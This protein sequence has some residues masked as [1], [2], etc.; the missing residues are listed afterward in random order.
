MAIA[1][2][3]TLPRVSKPEPAA[4][5]TPT[6]WRSPERGAPRVTRM[7][8]PTATARLRRAG[9][10]PARVRPRVGLPAKISLFLALILL[11]LAGMTWTLSERALRT[12]LTEEFTSKGT[13][14]ANSLASTG[15][16]LVLTRDASTVQALVDQFAAIS[17]VA[18]V[19]V[20][21]AQKTMIAHTFVPLVPPG[22]ID[23]NP[24]PGDAAK[25]QV[26]DIQYPDPVSGELREIIDIGVPML[27]GTIGTVR[28]G[29]NKALIVAAATKSGKSLLVVFVGFAVVAT[30]A[31]VIFAQRITRPVALLVRVAE[32]V[33][34]GDLSKAV[35]VTSHDEIGV[36][37]ETFNQTMVRLRGLV[38]TEAE[39]DE[40]RR[41]RE[42]LQLHITQFLDTVTEITKGDLTRRG[43]VTSDVLG[44]VVDATNV[45]VQEIATIIAGVRLAAG[46]VAQSSNEMIASAG[47][48]AAGSQ[49]Q[50]REAMAVASAVEELTRSVKQVAEIGE[51]AAHAARQALEASQ[52]GDQAVRNSLDGMQRIRGEVQAI[53]KKIKSLGDRSL[54][55][56]E[57]VNTIEEIA[58]QTNLLAL[59]AA[60]EAAGAGDAGLR[61]AV[62]ADEVR[63]LAERS[64]KATKD[65][66]AL[67]KNVHAETHDAIVVM[68]QGTNEVESGY[69]VTVQAGE[70]LKD[71]AQISQKS[72]E[73][74]HDISRA[75]Q[76][77]VR[78]A[79]GVATAVKSIAG[80]AVQTEQGALQTRKTVDQLVRLA[81]ELTA[82]LTRFKLST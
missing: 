31:G 17:G 8:T 12:R 14:I 57:I 25:A 75:T 54:E 80:V 44:N 9:E 72:A 41:R 45:M 34:Q 3:E 30:L 82:S 60:I 65:I 63:K 15:A 38:Q 13:A 24:V 40:E 19:M 66:A 5:V 42:E 59:N 46:R 33:G 61:F 52:R 55:I 62:V 6:V 69:R 18:Y 48:M 77:Q 49:A 11:P 27:A 20:Y 76:Q 74:A 21:D 56:S 28:V 39:R 23:R 16:D 26:R 32:R 4:G 68:E 43:E 10:L 35:P 51:A 2:T 78:G 53:S 1:T 64:A 7:D 22:I 50:T 37:A 79:E 58:S 29:M 36:L 70:S 67:I 81:E 73:L 71:I 47:K